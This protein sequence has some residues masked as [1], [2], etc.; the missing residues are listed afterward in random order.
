MKK[1]LSF[2]IAAMSIFM[3]FGC[4]QQQKEPF[5]LHILAN[6]DDDFDQQVKLKVRDRILEYAGEEMAE[7]KS[8]KEAEK[9]VTEHIDEIVA[10]A[11]DTLMQNGAD[12]KAR[13]EIGVF[14]FPDREYGGTI[15]PAGDYYALRLVLG[16]GDGKNWW[17]VMF[18]PLCIVNTQEETENVEYRSAFLDWLNEYIFGDL[19]IDSK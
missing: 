11:N 5:R 19:F 10:C 17:C 3:L 4:S 9:Y 13:A 8:E 15:Y 7:C 18:P 14:E 12:Y 16:N 1:I 2:M 6:R